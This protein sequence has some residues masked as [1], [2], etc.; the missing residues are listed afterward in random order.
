MG[1][2]ESCLLEDGLTSTSYN[3]PSLPEPSTGLKKETTFS[4]VPAEFIQMY[5][6][7]PVLGKLINFKLVELE[8][9]SFHSFA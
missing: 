6:V 9:D 7:G 8:F 4:D 5:K 3:I 1:I 2:C